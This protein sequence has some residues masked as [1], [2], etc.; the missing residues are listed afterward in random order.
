MILSFQMLYNSSMM[1][2]DAIPTETN[3]V[4]D[5]DLKNSK[6]NWNWLWQWR[7]DALNY[8]ILKDHLVK[9]AI[10]WVKVTG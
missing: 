8:N 1:G 9:V 3:N 5:A 7:L 10:F 2:F 6:K 4:F